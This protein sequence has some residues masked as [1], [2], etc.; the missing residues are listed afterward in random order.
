MTEAEVGTAVPIA[1]G[2]YT[3]GYEHTT[4]RPTS[5]GGFAI[6]IDYCTQADG[7]VSAPHPQTGR[8]SAEGGWRG[9][10]GWSSFFS[11]RTVESSSGATIRD[12]SRS[13]ASYIWTPGPTWA[14]I[15]GIALSH[16]RRSFGRGRCGYD[17]CPSSRHA[18]PDSVLS[19]AV[20]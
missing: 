3:G 16:S 13:W 7:T 15:I 10:D 1:P 4:S 19:R 14:S 17:R 18:E 12:Y 6:Y 9:Q 11:E 2:D 5:E 20:F 8:R